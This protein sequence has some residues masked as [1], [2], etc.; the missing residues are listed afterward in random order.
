MTS[1]FWSQG[2]SCG[3]LVQGGHKVSK[4]WIVSPLCDLG[5]PLPTLCLPWFPHV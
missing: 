2:L 3:I 4:T 1:E 5:Q